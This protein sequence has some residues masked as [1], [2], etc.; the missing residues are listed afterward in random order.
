[1]HDPHREVPADTEA[2]PHHE[3]DTGTLESKGEARFHENEAPVDYDDFQ[4]ASDS[5]PYR[6]RE[7]ERDAIDEERENHRLTQRSRT[8]SA[9]RKRDTED[10]EFTPRQRRVGREEI[11]ITRN[12]P[13]PERP[14]RGRERGREKARYRKLPAELPRPRVERIREEIIFRG[15]VG[16]ES[17]DSTMTEEIVRE[18]HDMRYEP[19]LPASEIIIKRDDRESE[20]EEI[21][22]RRD[23]SEPRERL[24]YE[25]DETEEIIRRDERKPENRPPPREREI[26]R[27]EIIIRRNSPKPRR[28]QTYD[29]DKTEEI[30]REDRSTRGLR[31]GSISDD[32]ETIIHRGDRDS[33]RALPDLQGGM[34]KNR[35][36]IVEPAPIYAPPIHREII[37]HV[38]YVH[39]GDEKEIIPAPLTLDSEQRPRDYTR[40]NAPL[41]KYKQS[42]PTEPPPSAPRRQSEERLRP[43]QVRFHSS[44]RPKPT[45]KDHV[46]VEDD[47]KDEGDYYN[48]RALERTYIGE[49]YEGETRNWEIVDV[50]PGTSKVQM[51]GVGG[52]KQEITW[53]RYNGVRRS[54]FFSRDAD[55]VRER[56]HESDLG[57]EK[58][59]RVAETPQETPQDSATSRR[60]AAN[61]NNE[62]EREPHT[63]IRRD[64]IEP[65]ILLKRGASLEVDK[66]DSNYLIIKGELTHDIEELCEEA[67][68]RRQKMLDE[69]MAKFRQGQSTT[70]AANKKAP[71]DQP[72]RQSI[73]TPV[74]GQRL[75][76]AD[77]SWTSEFTLWPDTK[78]SSSPMTRK[79]VGGRER[80]YREREDVFPSSGRVRES[81]R[82]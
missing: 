75:L 24:R 39:H 1:M 54:K 5:H 58:I 53:Q 65:E 23:T 41:R 28:R 62:R 37:Y 27:D 73:R 6:E 47:V 34:S 63:R 10:F 19:N 55:R 4:R 32:E 21:I 30:I 8:P 51:F 50:P 46:L 22:I 76:Q 14:L 66:D 25:E 48:Q 64:W 2:S 81:T 42:T 13:S 18:D 16:L 71:E 12:V 74:P 60:T 82:T 49:G 31:H 56:T 9:S 77:P 70:P 72:N 78:S 36:E 35:E 79:N 38:R 59:E 7:Q 11:T 17:R 29:D 43:S 68:Q 15:D 57:N 33:R 80:V 67:F 3:G 61:V 40:Q 44:A 26:E 52:A 20:R 69:D 45:D